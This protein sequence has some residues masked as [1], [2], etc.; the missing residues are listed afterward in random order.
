MPRPWHERRS[1]DEK[2]C[3][4]GA[5]ARVVKA[6][7]TLEVGADEGD[8]RVDRW[9]RRRFPQLSQG[10]IEKLVRTGQVRVDGA[11]VKANDRLVGGQLV[12][13]PPLPERIER[14]AQE[15]IS[16]KDEAFVKS[17]VIHRDADVIALNKPSGLAVQG[18]AKT[19]RHLDSLLDG[20]KFEREER[21]KLVHRLD[22]DTSGVL[23]LARHPRAA[24]YLTKSF[25]SR[26][27]QKVYWAVVLGCPRPSLGEIR[28]WLKKAGGAKES[29]HELIRTAAHGEEG[30]LFAITDYA[31]ISE[32]FPRLAWVALKPVTGRTHQLRFHM[33]GLGHAILGDGK[34]TCALERPGELSRQLHL[35]ARA[36]ETPHPNGSLLRVV[37][38]LPAHMDETFSALGFEKGDAKNPFAVFGG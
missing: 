2:S 18:G 23:L 13:I 30:A 15:G 10:V 8:V 7:E 35:H 24:A 26:E 3:I 22:K 5:A 11:R 37:A 14:P 17:L 6:V 19:G 31:V 32:A 1:Y 28:G 34:Y 16:A 12:R 9:L 38:P 36:V 27:T 33:A 29:D 25:R 20:L 4:Q 21:P